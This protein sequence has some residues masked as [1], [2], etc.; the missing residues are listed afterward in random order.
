[1]YVVFS[2]QY[3]WIIIKYTSEKLKFKSLHA[4]TS[5]KKDV[6]VPA[7]NIRDI[8]TAEKVRYTSC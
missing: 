8:K 4:E 6:H 5:K 2:V 7:K 3:D 1:M